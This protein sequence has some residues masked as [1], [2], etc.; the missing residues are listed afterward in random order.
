MTS[1]TV[2]DI[3]HYAIHDGPGIRTT[4]FLKGCPLSCWWCH[5]PEGL[6]PK[7][8]VIYHAERCI[9]C[10]RC[11]P[12]CPL[13]LQG[14]QVADC[15]GCAACAAVCPTEAR[16][17]VGRQ[18]TAR[19]VMAEIRKSQLFF[20][21]SGG[22]VTFSGGEPLLQ[23]EFLLALL[24]RCRD[25]EIHTAVETSGCVD[26]DTL[27]Q[28][29]ELT[30]LLLYDLKHMDPEQHLKY[31]GVSNE[32][33]RRNLRMLADMGASMQ[34]RMPIIPGVNDG[35][36]NLLRTAEFILSLP[37]ASELEILPYHSAA[38]EKYRKLG[39]PYLCADVV[40]PGS[41]RMQQIASFLKAKGINVKIGGQ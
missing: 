11:L 31:T 13:G 21:Q 30:D 2:F 5:N 33:I 8:V 22:G 7:P 25:E 29:A 23:A 14:P 16:Q 1:G 10:G 36:E 26:T 6:R 40:P 32:L 38:E 15:T 19:E 35:E 9:S 4:V 24:K 28:V 34:L 18:M 41:E 12:A 39:L 3:K 27:Q 37:D 20:D 17:L